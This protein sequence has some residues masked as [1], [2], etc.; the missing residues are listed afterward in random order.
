MSSATNVRVVLVRP[1]YSSN[2]G[3]V[4]RAM[5][6]FGFK[7]LVVVQQS[8]R[9]VKTKTAYMYAK[10]S[11]EVLQG[12]Q[13]FRTL[14]EALADCSLVVGTTGVTDRFHKQLKQCIPISELKNHLAGKVALLFG[15]EGTGLNE[16]ET[17][18]CDLLA[19]IPANPEH[20]VLNLSHAVAVVLFSLSGFQWSADTALASHGQ[21][22]MLEEKFAGLIASLPSVKDKKKVLLAFRRILGRSGATSGEVQALLAGLAGLEKRR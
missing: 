1:V 8:R 19:Y 21:R 9:A 16:V 6:N 18:A 17:A 14:N 4:C 13:V 5:K 7:E 12:A 15:S 10:H 3:L 11:K 2:V 22:R 20:A